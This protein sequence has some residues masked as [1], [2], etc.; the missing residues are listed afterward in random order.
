MYYN[1]CELCEYEQECTDKY[2]LCRGCI[3]EDS[4][5]LQSVFCMC[6][7]GL[8]LQCNNGYEEPDW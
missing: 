7:K 8:P 3:N 5:P 1:E 2:D 4:C 6:K